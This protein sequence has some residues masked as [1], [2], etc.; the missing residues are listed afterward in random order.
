MET[1]FSY[2]YV[3]P[4][5]ALIFVNKII[6]TLTRPFYIFC[7]EPPNRNFRIASQTQ[8][9][10]FIVQGQFLKSFQLFFFSST[11]FYL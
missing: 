8:K 10:N 4:Q 11:L 7:T 5:I 3:V 1:K 9:P 6:L 2:L